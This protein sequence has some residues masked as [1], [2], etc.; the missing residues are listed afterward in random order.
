MGI[1]T[2][3]RSFRVTQRIRNGRDSMAVLLTG[4]ARDA[5]RETSPY[6]P[7]LRR[8]ALDAS[9]GSDGFRRPR[10][11]M[12]ILSDTRKA[13]IEGFPGALAQSRNAH[14]AAGSGPGASRIIRQN[15]SSIGFAVAAPFSHDAARGRAR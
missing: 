10:D 15:N 13:A 7:L 2:A 6:D 14:K 11:L 5:H 3:E 9:G 1:P 4:A 12:T 8:R